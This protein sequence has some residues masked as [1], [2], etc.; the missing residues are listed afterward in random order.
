[1][2]K[3]LVIRQETKS[4]FSAITQVNDLAFLRPNEGK[5]IQQL[6]KLDRFDPRLSLVADL[7]GCVVG[8]ILF[9]PISILGENEKHETLSLGPLAVHPEHQKQGIGGKL[10]KGGHRV[11]QNLGHSSVVLLGHPTYYPRF[12]YKRADFWG[13]TNPWGI[14]NEAFMAVELVE[15]SLEQSSGLCE[16]PDEFNDAA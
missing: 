3:K 5:L 14:H 9:I 13:I 15:G 12:G 1:M 8:H 11:A 10:I 6:R 16:Y 7:G 2:N 4:D